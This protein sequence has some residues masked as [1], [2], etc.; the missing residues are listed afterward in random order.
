MSDQ[1]R[2]PPFLCSQI[3]TKEQLT[4]VPKWRGILCLCS[5]KTNQQSNATT[6]LLASKTTARAVRKLGESYWFM[7]RKM[8][9]TIH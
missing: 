3:L 9:I 6:V 5:L 4:S 8:N 2:A 7:Q 1:K